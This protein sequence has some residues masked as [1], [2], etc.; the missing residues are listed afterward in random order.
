VADLEHGRVL[1]A[2]SSNLLVVL[3]VVAAAVAVVWWGARRA[4]GT[5]SEP[6]PPLAARPRPIV[7]SVL[8][9]LL[10]V[11]FGVGRWLPALAW[12]AP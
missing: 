9:V 4:T 8:V 1:D 3:G 5:G 12:A 2:V 11:V 7:V 10:V 6:F